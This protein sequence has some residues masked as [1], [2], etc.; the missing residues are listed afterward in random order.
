[1]R[2][3][4]ILSN[5]GRIPGIIVSTYAADGLVD[6]RFME[7]AI[8]F[9]VAGAIAVLGIVLRDPIMRFLEK[10]SKGNR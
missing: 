9:V 6:G 1:M 7:S 2:T 5:I 4:L 3:F 10:R 8:I